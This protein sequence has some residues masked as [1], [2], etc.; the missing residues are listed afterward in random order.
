MGHQ[1]TG[2]MK[3]SDP[4]AVYMATE[5]TNNSVNDSSYEQGPSAWL[6]PGLYGRLSPPSTN[7]H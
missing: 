6:L 4:K 7:T 5:T 3:I 2:D 1:R